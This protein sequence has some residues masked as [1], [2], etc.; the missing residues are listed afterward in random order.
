FGAGE[1]GALPNAVRVILRWFPPGQRG[2]SQALI[3]TCAQIGGA[4][5]PAVAAYFIRSPYIGWRWSFVIFGALGVVW[6][7]FFSRWF[8]DDP[9]THPHVNDAERAYIQGGRANAP[10][11]ATHDEGI[12]W[13]LV[14]ASPNIWL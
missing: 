7:W 12:P 11:T 9:A 1:A 10:T 6:V 5:A 8:P 13:R 3:S 2:P 14:F 4:V